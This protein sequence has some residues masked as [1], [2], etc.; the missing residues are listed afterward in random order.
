MRNRPVWIYIMMIIALTGMSVFL[1]QGPVMAGCPSTSSNDTDLDGFTDNQECNSNGVAVAIPVFDNTKINLIYGKQN[2]PCPTGV[3]TCSTVSTVNSVTTTTYKHCLDPDKKDLFVIIVNP[4]N[5]TGTS[6]FPS[7]T[8]LLQYVDASTSAG[9]LGI[10]VH[11]IYQKISDPNDNR[12]VMAGSTQKA[13]KITESL[14]V[15]S[16]DVLGFSNTGTPN[17][18][19]GATIY[20]ARIKKFIQ[21]TCGMP[22]GTGKNGGAGTYGTPKCSDSSNP[23]LY[24]TNLLN[25]YILHTIAHE[26]GHVLGPLAAT[27]DSNYGGNHYPPN[28]N[29]IMDQSIYYTY[30][31]TNVANQ[32][33]FYIG[34]GFTDSDRS[35]AALVP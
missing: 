4:T 27:Y 8:D 9:G 7:N 35:R 24:G 25:K 32:T 28:T 31:N 22:G 19:D 21:D 15:K 11:P 3:A 30:D 34:T 1:V 26:V 33:T 12:T 6:L 29:V 2:C 20:T 16:M 13:A 17:G 18:K 5:P 23:P 14:D 10:A